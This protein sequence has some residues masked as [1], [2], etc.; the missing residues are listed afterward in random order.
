MQEMGLEPT[1]CCQRQILSLM[2]L[3]FRHSCICMSEQKRSR[4]NYNIIIVVELQELFC[5]FF[6]RP[7]IRL[8]DWLLL[9]S[10]IRVSK[11]LLH[12]LYWQ[13]AQKKYGKFLLVQW[14]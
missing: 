11:G 9:L 8:K 12:N 14:R 2:R 1:H 7:F 10:R 3:P 6:I 13:I 5:R 4:E